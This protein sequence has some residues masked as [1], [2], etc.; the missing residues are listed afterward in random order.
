MIKIL[1][2]LLFSISLFANPTVEIVTYPKTATNGTAFLL[3][4]TQD[5]NKTL[6][7][8]AIK[9]GKKSFKSLSDNTHILLPIYYRTKIGEH[10]IEVYGKTSNNKKF[11]EK[12]TIE[13][14]KGDYPSSKLT[15]SKKK[16]TFSKKDL[17]RIRKESK[18]A[19]K[20]YSKFTNKKYTKAFLYPLKT[21]ITSVY[22][23]RRVFNKKLKSYHSGTDF[24]AKMGTPIKASNDGVV[25]LV[26]NRFFAGGSVI[27]D[28]GE[29]IFSV[30]YHL[31]KFLVK[32]NQKIKRGDIIALSGDSGRV[33]GPH[34]HF[35]IV[36]QNTSVEP[37][38]FLKLMNEFIIE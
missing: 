8:L 29:G 35:G 18:N 13:V 20:I 15:V 32:K 25:K 17:K 6:K 23:V 7:K 22:G 28:H 31:S 33:T 11:S 16:T 21:K 27:I 12:F 4:V 34:L 1:S 38:K 10:N 5:N 2:I 19:T 3:K 14:K 30:Y 36:L 37:M 26:K 24:R 9:F